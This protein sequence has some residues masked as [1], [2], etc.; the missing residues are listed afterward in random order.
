MLALAA[1]IRVSVVI[2]AYGH[3]DYIGLTLASVFDQTFENYEVIVIDDG[4]PDKTEEVLKPLAEQGKISYFKQPN[5]GVAR[6]RNRGIGLAKG[7]FVALLDD[8]DIWP[9][10]RLE[11]MV[12]ALDGAP[13]AVMAYGGIRFIDRD[14][15][16]LQPDDGNGTPRRLP[17]DGPDNPGASG[18]VYK[19]FTSENQ[20]VSPGQT[21]IRRSALLAMDEPPCDPAIWGADDW[22][23][24]FKLLEQ[25]PAIYVDHPCLRYRFHNANASRN[26]ARMQ[27]NVL[28]LIKKHLRRQ[29]K[30]AERSQWLREGYQFTRKHTYLHLCHHAWLDLKSCSEYYRGSLLKSGFRNLWVCIRITPREC[31]NKNFILLCKGMMHAGFYGVK[32]KLRGR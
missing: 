16:N 28:K 3:A 11:K 12:Q 32:R 24:W 4:S 17:C 26:V 25:G 6:A 27:L 5:G 1:D 22:D 14:G 18:D 7:E 30:H 2:P 15:A 13:D 21:L 29:R 31:M 8:D 10:D 20:I 19:N 23:L 9:P